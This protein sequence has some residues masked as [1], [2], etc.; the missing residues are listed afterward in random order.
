MSVRILVMVLR[1]ES[2]RHM[3]AAGVHPDDII[4][5]N[6]IKMGSL[7]QNTVSNGISTMLSNLA[8]SLAI[9]TREDRHEMSGPLL[10]AVGN[11]KSI[12]PGIRT[13]DVTDKELRD[14][15]W[16]HEYYAGAAKEMYLVYLSKVCLWHDSGY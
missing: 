8:A 3:L 1:A 5:E 2:A 12:G 13:P 14:L 10:A 9:D 7:A 11:D 6:V 15:S 4:C 16:I